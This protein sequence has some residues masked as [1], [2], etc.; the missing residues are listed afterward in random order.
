LRKEEGDEIMNQKGTTLIELIIVLGVIMA[1]GVAL[2]L[3][4]VS[5]WYP[6]MY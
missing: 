4:N 2:V 6:M 3:P 5:T 1:V